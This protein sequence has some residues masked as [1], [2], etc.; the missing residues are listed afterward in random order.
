MV[1]FELYCDEHAVDDATAFIILHSIHINLEVETKKNSKKIDIPLN[2]F[3]FVTL[4][5]MFNV[6]SLLLLPF[7]FN[8]H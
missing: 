6:F 3:F 2:K 4:K 8:F 7:F 1:L 5:Y